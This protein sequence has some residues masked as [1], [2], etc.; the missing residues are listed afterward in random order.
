MRACETILE[1]KVE[2]RHLN[3]CD[4]A[5]P[6]QAHIIRVDQS[7]ELIEYNDGGNGADILGRVEGAEEDL[8]REG[9]S[10]RERDKTSRVWRQ[11]EVGKIAEEGGVLLQDRE[12]ETE[13]HVIRRHHFD[14]TRSKGVVEDSVGASR[15]LVV[16]RVGRCGR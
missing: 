15:L 4:D 2:A 1:E 16:R 12:V 7:A 3:G 14:I 9:R 13:A 11:R 5:V 10:V 8:E 6:D